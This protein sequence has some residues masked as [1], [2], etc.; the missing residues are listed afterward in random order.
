MIGRSLRPMSED[1]VS[2]LV[3]MERHLQPAPWDRDGFTKETEQGGEVWVVTDDETDSRIFGYLVFRK[4]E[5]AWQLLNIVVDAESRRKGLAKEMIR[6]MI[7]LAINSQT[8]RIQLQ[9]RKSNSAALQLYQKMGFGI[10][11]VQKAFYSNG[12]DAYHMDL[13]LSDS[14]P[15]IQI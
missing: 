13:I 4:S 9:V 8:S 7:N 2:V 5:D 15:Q 12:E 11:R 3:Q 1:D 14:E 6:K 10:T